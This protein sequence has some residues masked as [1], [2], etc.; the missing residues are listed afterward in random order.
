MIRITPTSRP[1]KSGLCV[2][3]VPADGA[4]SFFCASEPATASSGMTKMKRPIS[5]ATPIVVL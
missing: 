2:G 5:I 1:T 4:S 3:K